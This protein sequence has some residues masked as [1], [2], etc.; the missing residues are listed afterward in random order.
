M[1]LRTTE[2]LHVRS[3]PTKN[4]KS[5]GINP[6]NTVLESTDQKE[7]A[8]TIWYKVGAGWSSG[9]YL[10]QVDKSAVVDN[11]T[12]ANSAKLDSQEKAMVN[13]S[14]YQKSVKNA[15]V[16]RDE[17]TGEYYIR[18][19]Y[20][21]MSG[22]TIMS[23]ASI[24]QFRM[25]HGLPFQF[26]PSAD[27][28]MGA[29][30]G[31]YGR[32]YIREILTNIPIV[33]FIAG[34]PKYLAGVGILGGK[35]KDRL[36]GILAVDDDPDDF[37]N[38]GLLQKNLQYYTHVSSM[39]EYFEYVNSCCRAQAILSGLG[40]VKIDGTALKFMRWQEYNNSFGKDVQ[41]FKDGQGGL[42]D[43]ARAVLGVDTSIMFAYDP[44]GNISNNLSNSTGE[45]ALASKTKSASAMAREAEFL[46]G[47]GAGIELEFASDENIEQM[48]PKM[49]DMSKYNPNSPIQRV[50]RQGTT[51]ATGANLIFPEIWNDSSY[52]KDYAIDIKL[53]SPYADPLSRY[54]YVAVPFWHLFCL[55]GPRTYSENSYVAPFLIKAYSKGYFDVQLGMLDSIGIKKFGD[56]DQMSDDMI[57]MSLEL[58]VSFKD[59]YQA[60]SLAKI[61]QPSLFFNNTGLIDMIGTNSG[62]SMNR[63]SLLDKIKMFAELSVKASI[64]DIP[65]NGLEKL[66]YYTGMPDRLRSLLGTTIE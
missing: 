19:S 64:A 38:S 23:G 59:L 36:L 21:D 8:G 1:K 12:P 16:Y 32:T 11:P 26:L 63:A 9:A 28:R 29:D 55:G 66:Y 3:E 34:S 46:F 54:L 41:S 35:T 31:G 65:G 39:P 56:G 15:P 2:N 25:I 62:V 52:V 13:E 43:L 7:V 58:S 24:P 60:L 61:N 47:A 49:S 44:N 40:D 51:I 45:S 33:S 42:V 20:D 4:S 6:K 57:P 27:R 37:L 14:D 18:E 5:L 53:E 50:W 22:L 10:E 17:A 30:K 48:I